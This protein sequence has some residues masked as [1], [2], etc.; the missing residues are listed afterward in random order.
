MG[1]VWKARDTRLDRTVAVK[2]SQENFSERFEREAR[3]IAALNHPHICTLHDVGPNYLVME[4]VEGEPLKGPLPIEKAIHYAGQI[5]EALDHAHRKGITHRDLKP[6]NI[7]VT[8]QGIKLLDFGLAKL[9]PAPLKETDATLTQALS[10]PLTRDGQILGTLQ[11]MSPEQLQGKEADARSDLFSFG[12]VLYEMLTGK[13][14]FE[15][16]SAA[17]VIAAILERPAP[18]IADVAPPALDRVLKRCL[19]KDPD[20]RFQNALDL[21]VALEWAIL[22]AGETAAVPARARLGLVG[23]IAVGVLAIAGIGLGTSYYRATRS[24][25]AK[26]LVRLDVDVGADISRSASRNGGANVI[27]APD[28]SRIVYVAQNR[29]FTRK[30]DQPNGME[31]TGTEGAY[32][33]FF[34][35]DGQWVAFFAQGKLKKVLVEGGVAVILCDSPEGTGGSWGEGDEIIAALSNNGG[36]SQVPSGGG[37]PTPIAELNSNHASYRWPQ[38][39]PGG[40]ALLFTSRT[41]GQSFDQAS[42]EIFSFKDKHRKVIV[43]GG[44]YGRYMPSG[45]LVYFN[46]GTLFAVPFRLDTLEVAGT[47]VPILNQVSY[48]PINGSAA[49]D[50]SLSGTLIY[51]TGAGIG[52]FTVEWLQSDGTMQT[53]LPKPGVYGHPSLSPDGEKL[54]IDMQEGPNQDIWVYDVKRDTMT[55]LTSGVG[56]HTPV[57]SPDGRYI[58]FASLDGLHWTRADG[59]SPPQL[60][61]ATKNNASP[62]SFTPDGKRLAYHELQGPGNFDIWTASIVIGEAGL[63]AG[64]PSPYLATQ[65]SELHP[66]ISPDGKWIGYTSNEAGTTSHVFVR[67]FVTNAQVSAGKWQISGDRAAHLQWSRTAHQLFFWDGRHIMV[68]DYSVKG[69]SFLAEKPRVWSERD[70]IG[71]SGNR[72]YD[73]APDGQRIAAL[74]AAKGAGS[75][76]PPSHVIFL[77]NFFDE[78]QRKVPVG[79]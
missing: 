7:L 2:L 53:L 6:A 57:W 62:W 3:A 68:V 63:R 38:I 76:T 4:Y 27:L 11:Y 39:L 8:K 70:F 17:S 33:P 10:K 12:C 1:E 58:V 48:S 72:A 9:R 23:S 45:H 30:L 41:T 14:A 19:E 25:E 16:Q 73:V 52:Q 22:S 36:L 18:S 77:E 15:G 51:R 28:G 29:L 79:K 26:A 43:R 50:F 67:P 37:V 42:I 24:T 54:A 13:R 20:K 55:R 61:I 49:V 35:P 60:L 44:S 66:S 69:N 21:K 5:L 59:A 40:R 31:L 56:Y 65:A 78:L 75:E 64:K 32:A 71:D 47:P 46:A 34:S 74:I